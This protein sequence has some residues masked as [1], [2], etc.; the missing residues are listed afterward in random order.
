MAVESNRKQNESFEAFMRRTKKLWQTS[1][2]LLQVKKVQ[3]FD[4]PK[5]K[6]L[7]KKKAVRKKKLIEKTE[8]LRKTGKLP[9]EEQRQYQRRR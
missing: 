5:S 9:E 6:N 4:E 3:Y 2:K 8:Y 7:R 1:G